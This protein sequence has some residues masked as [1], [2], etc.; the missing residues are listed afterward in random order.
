MFDLAGHPG[1]RIIHV[2]NG[3]DGRSGTLASRTGDASEESLSEA[4]IP[5]ANGGIEAR[6]EQ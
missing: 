1:R 3:F 2:A 6:Y 4:V 5:G